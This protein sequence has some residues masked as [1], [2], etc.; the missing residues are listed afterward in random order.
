MHEFDKYLPAGR[1]YRNRGEHTFS[2]CAALRNIQ[3]PNS[4][5][6]LEK[7]VFGRSGLTNILVGTNVTVAIDQHAFYKCESLE[8]IVIPKSVRVI[9]LWAFRESGLTSVYFEGSKPII[10]ESA[11]FIVP[12]GLKMY[13]KEGMAGWGTNVFEFPTAVWKP[14]S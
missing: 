12:E 7:F 8:S 14:K 6:E 4:L 5:T 1:Y 2:D 3:L 13:Y 9:K 10:H 11:F